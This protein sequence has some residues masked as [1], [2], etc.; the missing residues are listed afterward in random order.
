MADD[1]RPVGPGEITRA[2]RA[3]FAGAPDE[4]QR[5]LLQRLVECLHGYA[6]DVGLTRAEWEAA[7]AFLTET[8]QTCSERRQEFILLSDT[9]G[10]SMLVDALDHPSPTGA[11]ESTVLGPFH[12]AG[13]PLRPMGSSTVEQDGSGEPAWV[14]GTVRGTDGRPVAGALLDVWQNA[15]NRLYAVQ[16]AAQPPGN[17]R[18][19]F[20]TGTDGTFAFWSVRPVDYPIPDDGPVGRLLAATGRHPWRPAHLHVMVSAPGY[21]PVATHFFDRA[22]PYLDSDAVFGV[23]PSLVAD[24]VPH[25]PAEPGAPPGWEGTWYSL[26]KDV[27]LAPLGDEVG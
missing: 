18:G 15:A 7:V 11:T 21:R 20:R 16:D 27:V 24:F 1:R 9:L 23:K 4:R 19:R 8:G 2:A 12:V 10:L 13:A 6:S 5:F 25:A 3:S 17:L 22:S 26:E 14:T